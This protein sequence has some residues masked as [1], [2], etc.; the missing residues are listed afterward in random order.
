MFND[1]I[2]QDPISI[3]VINTCLH[4]SY[5]K[6]ICCKRQSIAFSNSHV[7]DSEA[8]SKLLCNAKCF[9]VLLMLSQNLKSFVEQWFSY[10]YIHM[11][12]LGG[13]YS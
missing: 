2:S 7:G 9:A 6:I 5:A 3:E 1:S 4:S 13:I 11:D 8:I 12:A 10:R